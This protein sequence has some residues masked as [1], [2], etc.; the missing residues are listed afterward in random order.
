M[1]DT[2]TK[3]I[4]DPKR[5]RPFGQNVELCADIKGLTLEAVAKEAKV[6]SS[7]LTSF[8]NGRGALTPDV[9]GRLASVFG[10]STL[11]L[12]GTNGPLETRTEIFKKIFNP[13]QPI[14]VPHEDFDRSL[15]RGGK[16]FQWPIGVKKD[17]SDDESEESEEESEVDTSA[18]E[19]EPSVSSE[20]ATEPVDAPPAPLPV[21]VSTIDDTVTWRSDT[22]ALCD[23]KSFD[24]TDMRLRKLLGIRLLSAC[25]PVI[26]TAFGELMVPKRSS[27][28]LHNLKRGAIALTRNDLE[29]AATIC[30]VPLSSLLT[31][32]G[33]EEA[34]KQKRK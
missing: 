11:Q 21:R 29:Q 17:D 3:P 14:E 12:I 8:L 24:L 22:R 27:S 28:W 32:H 9:V 16:S 5:L 20:P 26:L 19:A 13:E 33:L 25:Q 30:N 15:V 18:P 1:S 7:L 4:T 34:I 31:G 6:P 2:K 10:L 23:G